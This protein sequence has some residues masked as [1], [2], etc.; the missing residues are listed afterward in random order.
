MVTTVEMPSPGTTEISSPSDAPEQEVYDFVD[1][2]HMDT[3]M[4]PD[5][6]STAQDE[7][8]A[9][10]EQ[11]CKSAEK[12]SAELQETIAQQEEREVI[13]ETAGKP[14][15][16]EGKQDRAVRRTRGRR[17]LE[18]N[19]VKGE[20]LAQ[21]LDALRLKYMRMPVDTAEEVAERKNMRIFINQRAAAL[22]RI[23]TRENAEEMRLR[24]HHLETTLATEVDQVQKATLLLGWTWRIL[25]EVEG[26]LPENHGLGTETCL[27][28]I[29]VF[30][31]GREGGLQ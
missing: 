24:V 5:S 12:D 26:F 13:M 25:Q 23:Q 19:D 29:E 14:P 28:E 10:I 9:G 22:N 30:L 15:R 21:E 16:R 8:W 1:I 20:K 18:K 11:A 7:I 3:G 2:M 17:T 4:P 6:L 27:R 31:R